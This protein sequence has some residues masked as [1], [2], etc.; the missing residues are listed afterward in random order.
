[1]PVS[2]GNR[3]DIIATSVGLIADT[4]IVDEGDGLISTARALQTKADAATV[5]VKSE[6]Y[7]RQEIND[8]ICDLVDADGTLLSS[9]ASGLGRKADKVTTYT[10]VD[11]DALLEPKAFRA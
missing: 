11:E 5:Y 8:L 7:N 3:K 10:K 4:Q 1:M 2:L 6:T 9:V